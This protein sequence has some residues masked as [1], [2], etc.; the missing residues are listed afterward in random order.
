MKQMMLEETATAA[1]FV[2][3]KRSIQIVHFI[4]RRFTIYLVN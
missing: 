2:S 4:S 3:D 1:G